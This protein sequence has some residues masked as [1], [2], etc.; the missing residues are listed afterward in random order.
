MVSAEDL[1]ALLRKHF[2]NCHQSKSEAIQYIKLYIKNK[3]HS[4][5]KLDDDQG[6]V[7]N[8]IDD[9]YLQTREWILDRKYFCDAWVD[10]NDNLLCT[11]HMYKA[12]PEWF[13]TLAINNMTE[14]EINHFMWVLCRTLKD[15]FSRR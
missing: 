8:R 13:E 1:A 10:E 2:T 6:I 4:K 12:E 15:N 5:I 7:V 14:D 11:T 3:P 9:Y